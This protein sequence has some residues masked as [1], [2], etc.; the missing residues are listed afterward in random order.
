[1]DDITVAIHITETGCIE[2][3]TVTSSINIF[4]LI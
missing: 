1:M 3:D 4:Y 2:N